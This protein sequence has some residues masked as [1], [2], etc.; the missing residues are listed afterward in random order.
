MLAAATDF[1]LGARVAGDMHRD[2]EHGTVVFAWPM[3]AEIAKAFGLETKTTG[4]MIAIKPD[5]PE[6]LEK[7]RQGDYTGFSI[8]GARLQQEV[9]HD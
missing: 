9:V 4:L 1:M 6:I 7:F 2:G 8:A 3:T 5:D